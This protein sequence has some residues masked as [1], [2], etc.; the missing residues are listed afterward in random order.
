MLYSS[1][2]MEQSA[3]LD[4][5]QAMCT[6]ARTAPK[7]KGVDKIV[8]M[9]ITGD[10]RLTLADKMEE[11][12]EMLNGANRSFITRDAGCVRKAQAVVLI[13]YEK[14][15]YGLN[16]KNCGFDTCAACQEAGGACLFSGID[17]GIA[18]GSAVSVAENS[19]VDNRVMYSV[20]KCAELMNY[21]AEDVVLIGIPLSISGKNPFFDRK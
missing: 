11:T 13:G 8:T 5:A 20:G 15:Y 3:L 21:F 18:V 6:A 16:C 12:D 19:R 17:L 10:D 4:V 7:T 2:E 1:Q 14:H 9:V